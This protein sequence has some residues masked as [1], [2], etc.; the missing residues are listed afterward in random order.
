MALLALCLVALLALCQPAAGFSLNAARPIR[1]HA[2]VLAPVMDETAGRGF[3]NQ[4]MSKAQAEERGRVA[5]EAMRQAN[6]PAPPPTP[7]EDTGAPVAAEGDPSP[8]LGLAGFFIV[9]GV[10]ALFVGGPL[11]ESTGMSPEDSMVQADSTPAFGFVPKAA[12]PPAP[13]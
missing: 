8:V 11:W 4:E 7:V 1:T 6:A 9:V 10:T 3:A 5:L 2:R 13:Q 12:A